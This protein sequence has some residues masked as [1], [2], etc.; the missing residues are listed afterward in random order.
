MP[1]PI[2]TSVS[3]LDKWKGGVVIRGIDS[4]SLSRSCHTDLS[5]TTIKSVANCV[6]S[7]TRASKGTPQLSDPPVVLPLTEAWRQKL[8][9]S[10]FKLNISFSSVLLYLYVLI[11]CR[12]YLHNARLTTVE[13]TEKRSWQTGAFRI[14]FN[15]LLQ[16]SKSSLMTHREICT[17][18]HSS[19]K[20]RG[21]PT[22]HFISH[23]YFSHDDE[24]M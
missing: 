17:Q 15:Q 9:R 14:L 23:G 2:W 4:N 22:S 3:D 16:T 13:T 24:S 8:I 5:H 12:L 21:L 1:G 18:G 20:Q 11:D 7:T 10:T 6:S 19:G